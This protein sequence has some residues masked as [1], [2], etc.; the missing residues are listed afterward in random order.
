[1]PPC[2]LQRN[3]KVD[4]CETFK[5]KVIFFD[6]YYNIVTILFVDFTKIKII[7]FNKYSVY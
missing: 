6:E 3:V 5:V 1:M 7:T 4:L 2:N